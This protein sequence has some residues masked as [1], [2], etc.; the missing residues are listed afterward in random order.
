MDLA[1]RSTRWMIPVIAGRGAL[2]EFEIGARNKNILQNTG[3]SDEVY[4]EID[5]ITPQYQFMG[6]YE[7]HFYF[8]PT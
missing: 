7:K 3:I 8:K 4:S 5:L 2:L 1:E 6:S